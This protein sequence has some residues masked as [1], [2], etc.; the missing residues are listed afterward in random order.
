MEN[1]LEELIKS[2]NEMNKLNFCLVEII[3]DMAGLINALHELKDMVEMDDIKNAIVRQIQMMLVLAYKNNGKFEGQMLHGV[4]YGPPGVGKTS[5]AKIIA[6]IFNSIGVQKSVKMDTYDRSMSLSEIL[7]RVEKLK[8]TYENRLLDE[9]QEI[10]MKMINDVDDEV[11]D[12]TNVDQI[13]K[14]LHEDKDESYIVICGRPE[15][16]A[17][18]AGQTSI[19]CRN[20][21]NS[22]KGKMIIIEEAYSLYTGERDQFGL[23]ALTELNRFMDENPNDIIVYFTGYKDMIENTIFKAQPG[24]KRRCT[25]LFE[26]P[27]YSYRGLAKVFQTQLEKSGWTTTVDLEKF[28]K[29][30]EKY[31]PH[32]GG[33]TLRLSFHAK[34]VYSGNVFKNFKNQNKP[35]KLVIDDEILKTAFERYKKLS[36][37]NEVKEI[38]NMYI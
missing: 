2:L 30:N 10:A 16:V 17:E 1:E 18:Y 33:D 31:F 14:G 15:L 32:Y 7:I 25:F 5:V 23:E 29:G 20:F 34:Q 4:I 22:N 36:G 37:I 26:I 21:L 9:I 19:K 24:L 28:F 27:G 3:K 13:P 38:N 8:E 35:P 6:K 12:I 11:L